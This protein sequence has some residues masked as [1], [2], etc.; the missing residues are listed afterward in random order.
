MLATV[1]FPTAPIKLKSGLQI[2]ARLL[3]AIHLDQSNYL[4][5]QKQEAVSKYDLTVIV[6]PFKG[7]SSSSKTRV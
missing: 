6:R 5:N 3:L 2:G 1:F 7:S 4:A